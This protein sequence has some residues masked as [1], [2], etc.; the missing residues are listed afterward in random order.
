MHLMHKYWLSLFL[1][2]LLI[3]C[4]SRDVYNHFITL[5]EETWHTDSL[6]H[7]NFEIE[8]STLQYNVLLNIRHTNKYPWQNLWIFINETNPDS[9]ITQDTLMVFLADDFGK[10]LGTGSSSVFNRPVVY[11]AKHRFDRSGNYQFSIVHGMRDTTLTG[12]RNIGLRVEKT[13]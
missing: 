2:P 7:F 4:G 3:S 9:I 5:G 11:R 6:V 12:I 10:W 13:K 1:L 8:D